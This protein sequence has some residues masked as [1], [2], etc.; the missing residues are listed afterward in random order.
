M[1]RRRVC[2]IGIKPSL[3][4]PSPAIRHSPDDSRSRR[5]FANDS[6]R[7]AFLTRFWS[8]DQL[9]GARHSLSVVRHD[10][11]SGP[12]PFRA[13]LLPKNPMSRPLVDAQLAD[14][15]SH[16]EAVAARDHLELDRCAM[17]H[18]GGDLRRAKIH[19][20]KRSKVHGLSQRLANPARSSSCSVFCPTTMNTCSP[21]SALS[22]KAG[23]SR[24]ASGS[25]GVPL[26][27]RLVRVS[28]WRSASDA[29]LAT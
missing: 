26:E 18:P 20:H 17:P 24:C 23:S 28:K 2:C 6:R 22:A 15:D 27:R 14:G 1:K 21:R 13:H 16:C 5:T 9:P 12:T 8:I 7:L 10:K 19:Q 11:A 4:V 29:V 25:W 3:L